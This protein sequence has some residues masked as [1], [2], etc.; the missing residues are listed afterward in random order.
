VTLAVTDPT[1]ETSQA[2]SEVEVAPR[3]EISGR[4]ADRWIITL[5]RRNGIE[6]GDRLVAREDDSDRSGASLEVVE[7][8]GPNAAACRALDD[9]RTP[10]IGAWIAPA[11]S[12]AP[13]S[14]AP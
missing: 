11:P 9:K 5:G 13:Q 7:V 10:S 6:T 1:G 14:A 8:L 12:N 2:T 3:G 4:D